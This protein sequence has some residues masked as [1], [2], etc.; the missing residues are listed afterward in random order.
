MVP[1]N[2]RFVTKKTI[3]STN[4]YIKRKL[5]SG[6]SGELCVWAVTQ[7]AG[8]G[9]GENNWISPVGGLYLSVSFPVDPKNPINL[10][11]P[12]AAVAAASY[13]K[14]QF[15]IDV[16]FKWPNDL[17]VNQKKLAGFLL[18]LVQISPGVFSV[19]VGF[20]MNINALPPH[21]ENMPFKPTSIGE[22]TQKSNYSIEKIAR[23]LGKEFIKLSNI[24]DLNPGLLLKTIKKNS[25]TIGEKVTIYQ[26]GGNVIEGVA[27]DVASDFSLLIE[28]EGIISTVKAGDCVHTI[29]MEGRN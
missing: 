1:E 20:G 24:H 28:N 17:L 22:L 10:I 13:V 11:G 25:A 6:D 16:G 4:N 23:D 3:D 19:I 18:E 14:Q 5:K 8:R 12:A 2:F 21:G 15:G 9:R 7:T 29:A 27:V 26:T